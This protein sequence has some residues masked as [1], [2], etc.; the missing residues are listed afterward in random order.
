LGLGNLGAGLELSVE[1]EFR[2]GESRV[3]NSALLQQDARRGAH[4]MSRKLSGWA[5]AY[6]AQ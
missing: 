6:P 4:S 5:G 1:A 3:V 2:S